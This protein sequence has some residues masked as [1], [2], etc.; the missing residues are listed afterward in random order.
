MHGPSSQA[1]LS[2]RG[3]SGNRCQISHP[4]TRFSLLWRLT[5]RHTADLPLP[6]PARIRHSKIH[7]KRSQRDPGTVCVRWPVITWCAIVGFVPYIASKKSPSFRTK[8]S[9]CKGTEREQCQLRHRSIHPLN[10]LYFNGLASF[11]LFRFSQMGHC[12]AEHCCQ[13]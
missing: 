10:C 3:V 1:C 12:Q 9:S 11:R 7:S 8:P 4:S 5:L 13:R 2:Y 6:P